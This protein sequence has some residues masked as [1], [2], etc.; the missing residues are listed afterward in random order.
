MR[1]ILTFTLTL[2]LV[3]CSAEK[4]STEDPVAHDEPSAEP[5]VAKAEVE[6]KKDDK[7]KKPSVEPE[8]RKSLS[9]LAIRG[10]AEAKGHRSE[11]SGIYQE[12]RTLLPEHR[13]E[14]ASLI[15]KLQY[16]QW[17][18]KP[19]DLKAT[20][21]K[22][23]EFI[24]E[25]STLGKKYKSK[26]EASHTQITTW[27]KEIE[28]G[29]KRHRDSKMDTFKTQRNSEM[30]VY[31]SFNLL[32]RSLVDEAII[33]GRFGSWAMQDEMKGLFFPMK[34]VL[35]DDEQV[36]NSYDTLLMV[37]GVPAAERK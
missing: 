21:L 7:P 26:G 34:E 24:E 19:E 5:E 32:M 16:F 20:P 27:E 6:K 30:K 3:A 17:S 37:L 1:L 15:D 22:L 18:D 13:K 9:L 12:F 10:S 36:A 33:Y 2:A 23:K 8:N 14:V 28:E 29:K 11:R 4:P 31:R 25:C 35:Q